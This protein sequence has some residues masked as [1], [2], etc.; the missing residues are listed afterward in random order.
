MFDAQVWLEGT[1]VGSRSG[2]FKDPVLQKEIPFGVVQLSGREREAVRI[3]EINLADGFD[4]S[5][6]AAGTKLKIPVRIGASKD[7][8]KIYYREVP[9]TETVNAKSAADAMRKPAGL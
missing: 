5:R 1:I 9:A 7:G 3:F 8:R 6:Y 4:M 2:I